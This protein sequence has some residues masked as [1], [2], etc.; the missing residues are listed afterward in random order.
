MNRGFDRFEREFYY[1]H[2]H[3]YKVINLNFVNKTVK[4]VATA[5][6]DI[7]YYAGWYKNIR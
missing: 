6:S 3:Y 2:K 1:I 7:R 4:T 5:N